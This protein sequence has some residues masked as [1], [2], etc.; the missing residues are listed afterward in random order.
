MISINKVKNLYDKLYDV[1]GVGNINY[2]HF[3][4]NHLKPIYMM[5]SDMIGDAQW[6]AKH[7]EMK[8]GLKISDD[9]VLKRIVKGETVYIYDV[10]N[11]PLASPA[12]RAFGIYSLVVYPLYDKNGVANSLICIPDFFKL[13]EFTPEVIEKCGA[14]I[15][16]FN[17]EINEDKANAKVAEVITNYLGK[18]GVKQI[19]SNPCSTFS[20]IGDTLLDMKEIEYI[21]VS[22]ESCASFS[23]EMYAKLSGNLG[24]CLVS[25]AVG[26]PNA[27]NGIL[28]AKESKSPILILSGYA[29]QSEQGLGAM[30]DFQ[31]HKLLDSVV[32]Y[33]KVIKNESEVLKELKKAIE[34]AMIPPRGPVHIGIPLNIL[35]EEFSGTDLD[36]A[37]ILNIINDKSQF[38]KT[39]LAI[40][41]SKN[42]LII[43][44]GG[45]RGLSKEVISLAEKLDS[46]MVTTTGGKGVL[47]EDHPLN[48]GNFGF[49]GTDIANELVLNDKSIDTIIALGT[50]LTA[51]ATLNFDKRLTENRTLIQIDTDSA[52]FNKG[53]NADISLIS[54]LKFAL[55]YLT[56]NVKQKD[57]AFKKLYL[58]KPTKKTEGLCLRDVYENLGDI[59]P[60]NTLYISDIGT[61]MHYS[62]KFLKVPQKGDFYCNTLRACMGS[63]I[64]AIGASFIDKQ[65]PVVTLV[66][67]GSF[68]MNYMGELPTIAKY[69]LPIL[70]IV[71]NN[72]ALEYV[73]IG[74]D[75][76]HGRHPECLESKYINIHQISEGLGIKCVQVKSLNDLEFLRC[77]K[78]EKPFVVE[79]IID[80]TS[81]MPLGR[82]ELLSKH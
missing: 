69:N 16:E 3:N 36:A 26:I 25:G 68:L 78:F 76:I 23:A 82:L 19:F 55:N 77:Y 21:R 6:K 71:L 42:S 9:I 70:T 75:V 37:A 52:T 43:V 4:G 2:H 49:P 11:D 27:L 67:D 5:G 28:Q 81:D 24:V 32:K 40:N 34:V 12:F 64:G 33:N 79:L 22:N 14:L 50:Q 47:S 72:S 10:P 29:N 80:D 30:H 17:N 46:K 8:E 7:A 58:N 63:S 73:R 57:R 66:G 53:Y 48:L 20:P 65:R 56:E 38:N 62:Y 60:D 59:L 45:C 13:N 31:A 74:H 15:K 41:E 39:I 1:C 18:N 35:K 51:M 54:D 44:G 61:S